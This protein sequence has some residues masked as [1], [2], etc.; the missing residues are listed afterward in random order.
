MFVLSFVAVLLLSTAFATHAAAQDATRSTS[1]A[2]PS[3]AELKTGWNVLRPGGDTTCAKGTEYAFFVR[4]GDR[5]KLLVFFQGG[6]AC[7]RGEECDRGQPFYL[8]EINFDAPAAKEGPRQGI[9]NLEHPENPFSPYSTVFV[10]YCTGDVHLGDRDATYTVKSDNGETRQFEIHHRGQ[11]NATAVL[12]WIHR[13]FPAP[14]EIFVSGTSA[15]SVATPF[16]ASALARHYPQARVVGL[17][18]AQGHRSAAIPGGDFS[19]WGLPDVLRRHPGWEQFPDKW[20]PADHYI[21]AAR[22]TPRLRLFQFNHAYDQVTRSYMQ[23]AGNQNLDLLAMLRANHREIGG[24]VGT[25]R[26]FTVGGRAH[27]VMPSD[28]F[29]AYESDG[30]RFRDWVAAIAA[31]Q[32]V[33]SV[34]CTD[35]TRS[36]FRFS[37]QDLRIAERSLALLS[38]AGAWNPQD[39][40][41]PCPAGGDRYT[42]RCSLIRAIREVTG[43]PPTNQPPAVVWEMEYAAIDRMGAAFEQVDADQRGFERVGAIVL[44]N[45]RPGATA[46]DVISL[47][48]EVRDRTR[49]N[50][51]RRTKQ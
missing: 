26:F 27:G 18:D 30:H 13:N 14:R 41:K 44:Y 10:R 21:T 38:P 16:Y 12:Q 24:R 49:A 32:P 25:F 9:F 36:E 28:R 47:M 5:D 43:R 50:L 6:G 31:G 51:R 3:F 35:C 17:G 23:L 45:N 29:Y 46:A 4:P 19:R 11:V 39:D 8:P 34:D 37:E 15:G 7:S 33:A 40:R 20:G 1:A 48:E 2:L 22:A 42:L